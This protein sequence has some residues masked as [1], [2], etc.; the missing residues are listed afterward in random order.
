MSRGERPLRVG[1]RIDGA[2]DPRRSLRARRTLQYGLTKLANRDAK[3]RDDA[4]AG[5]HEI[6]ARAFRSDTTAADPR[7]FN[8]EKKRVSQKRRLRGA[9]GA[10]EIRQA[11]ALTNLEFLNDAK[12]GM[13]LL[14][15]FDRRI[16]EIAA[17]LVLGDEPSGLVHEAVKL[18]NRVPRTLGFNFGP[19]FV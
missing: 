9:G 16:G 6:G 2:P 8:E 3:G 5:A 15:Q 13:T 10:A 1:R 14:G 11:L 4:S 7:A 19:D 17:A 12:T 18:T